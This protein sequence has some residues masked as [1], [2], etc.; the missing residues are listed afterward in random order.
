[1]LFPDEFLENSE[2]RM[3]FI[4]GALGKKGDPW[5]SLTV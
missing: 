3:R 1:M 2:K 5:V 4:V